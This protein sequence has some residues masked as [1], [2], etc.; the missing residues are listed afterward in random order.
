MNTKAIIEKENGGVSPDGEALRHAFELFNQVGAELAS[1]YEALQNEVAR[2][3]AELA[4]ARSEKLQQLA[5][6]ERLAQRLE[7][8]MEMLPGG[9]LVLDD[10]GVIRQANPGAEDLLGDGLV[11]MAWEKV[12]GNFRRHPGQELE[13]ADGRRLSLSSRSLGEG[14]GR[15]LLLTD[16][17]ETRRLQELASQRERLGALGEMAASLA[18]QIRTPLSSVLLYLSQL[19]N[20]ALDGERRSL[21]VA[22]ARERLRHLEQMVHNMLG[23][24][25]GEGAC[26]EPVLLEQVVEQFLQVLEPEVSARGGR[27]QVQGRDLDVRLLGDG[28]ALLG[29]LLNLGTNALQAC[30]DSPR[31]EL[32]LEKI[33]GHLVLTLQDNGSGFPQEA[34]DRLC[35]PF[36]TTRPNGTGLGLAV[37]KA[38]AESF[39]GE[40]M[41]ENRARGGARVRLLLPLYESCDALPAQV[42]EPVKQHYAGAGGRR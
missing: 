21:F 11:E 32:L 29:A 40:L 34:M 2:L 10:S 17:T 23:Y 30:G 1:R 35:E 19:D 18:H 9:V 8:L 39:E 31:I 38:V 15:I 5:E 14:E 42:L 27:L 41:L 24:A 26:R 12:A 25:R 36:F 6:K 16:V 3:T 37:V 22:R 13:L 7:R 28:D 4:Q 20:P 33:A